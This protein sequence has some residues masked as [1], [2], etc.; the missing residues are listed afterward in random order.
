MGESV[1][2]VKRDE[3]RKKKQR[4]LVRWIKVIQK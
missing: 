2:V 4:E 1:K 3:G